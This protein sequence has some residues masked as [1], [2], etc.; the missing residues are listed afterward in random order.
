[1][2]GEVRV[3]ARKTPEPPASFQFDHA[4]YSLRVGKPRTV[5]VVAPRSAAPGLPVYVSCDNADVAVKRGGVLDLRECS[6][7]SRLEGAVEVIALRSG[8]RG[9]LF[10][11]SG[12]VLARAMVSTER[13]GGPKIRVDLTERTKGANR[14]WWEALETERGIVRQLWITV[15]DKSIGRYLGQA[16]DGRWPGQDSMHFR[17]LLAEIIAEEVV[18][19]HLLKQSLRT[20]DIATGV[21]QVLF[22]IQ[23]LKQRFLPIA[24]RLMIPSVEA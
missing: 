3:A 24:H 15:R 16:V 5:R 7:P 14:S 1:L 9:N 11:R 20:S 4:H 22:E 8:L 17:M 13:A 12:D 10:A 2:L 21:P 23:S 18:R 6:E 19:E